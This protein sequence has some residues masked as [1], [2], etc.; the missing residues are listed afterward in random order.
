[1]T[2]GGKVLTRGS[3]SVKTV[4]FSRDRKKEKK[5][6]GEGKRKWR[7]WKSGEKK[8]NGYMKRLMGSAA[9]LGEKITRGSDKIKG[10]IMGRIPTFLGNAEKTT[11]N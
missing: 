5:R 6:I 11:S 1:M 4:R 10:C 8:E 9:L 7:R 2:T 3:P